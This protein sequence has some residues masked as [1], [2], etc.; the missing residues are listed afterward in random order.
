MAV[1]RIE[2]GTNAWRESF[3]EHSERYATFRELYKGVDVLDAACGVGYGTNLISTWGA[4]SVVGLDISDD[5]LSY[6][7]SHFEAPGI[8]FLKGDCTKLPFESGSFD[9][10]VS[11]ETLEHIREAETVVAEFA[12]CLR[13]GGKLIASTPNR[14]AYSMGHVEGDENPFHV[15]EM[16]LPEFKALIGRH[17]HIESVLHQSMTLSHVLAAHVQ[18]LD[19]ALSRSLVVKCENFLRRLLGK[20]TLSSA[21]PR[22]SLEATLNCLPPPVVPLPDPSVLAADELSIFV[23]VASKS[24]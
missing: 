9:L 21:R 15:N 11:F 6:A 18:A 24:A 2:P 17:L 1:E 4:K 12:R 5:A 13:P 14:L 23:I 10:I 16:T 8:Q 19:L 22:Q 20:Q 7:R 3:A